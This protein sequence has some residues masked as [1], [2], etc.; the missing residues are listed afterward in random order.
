M[1]QAA[2]HAIFV[3]H[4]TPGLEQL[5]A[6]GELPGGFDLFWSQQI[7]QALHWQEQCPA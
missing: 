2:L 5:L 7:L 1:F 3:R 6:A 4:Q